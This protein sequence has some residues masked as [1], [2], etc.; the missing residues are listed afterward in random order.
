MKTK[1]TAILLCIFLGVIGIHRF[2]LGYKTIGIIQLLT[3][4]GCLVWAIIDLVQIANGNM[5][6][7]DGNELV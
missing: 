7:V 6:D 3:G 5:S 2:Y 4:G 1:T